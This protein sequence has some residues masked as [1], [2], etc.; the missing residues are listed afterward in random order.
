MASV[1]QKLIT[2]E[3]YRRLEPPPDGS[4]VELVRGEL[5]QVCRP[6]FRHG[7][8]QVR[9]SSLLDQYAW[10]KRLGRVVVETGI[11]TER[12]PDTVR[13]PD[14]SY[15]SA[16]TLPLSLIPAG[17][18]DVAPDLAIE[19]LSPSNVMT[20]IRDKM[21]EYFER[22]VRMVWLID[23]EARTLTVYRSLDEGQVLHEAAT[24][25]ADDI[26][27]GFRCQVA[28]LFS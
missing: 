16:E 21:R 20:K 22:G 24:V 13:G 3:E 12:D 19:V 5:I 10:P 28:D 15:W 25:Q 27:P 23:P 6:G 14:V 18:P 4:R 9:V 8:S 1:T 2:A 11:V 26:L 17:Y 7:F